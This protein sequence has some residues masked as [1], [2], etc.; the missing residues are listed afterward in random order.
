VNRDRAGNFLK[1]A[2][3]INLGQGRFRFRDAVGFQ[4]DSTD[5]YQ[6]KLGTRSRLNIKVFRQK[7]AGNADVE[8][9]QLRDQKRPMMRHIGRRQFDDLK[10]K[11]IRQHLKRV[12]RSR[13]K[14]RKNE[15]LRLTAEPGIYYIH[16]FPRSG[17][18]QYRLNIK[19]RPQ[20]PSPEPSS[21][22]PASSFSPSRSLPSVPRISPPPIQVTTPN[23][24]EVLTTGTSVPL[25]W[26]DTFD[27]PVQIDLFANNAKVRT[28][29][30]QT[31]SDGQFQWDIPSTLLSGTNYTIRISQSS[32]LAIF[33]DSDA[34]FGIQQSNTADPNPQPTQAFNIQFDYRFDTQ[35]WFTPE[36]KAVLESAAKFWEDIIQDDFD[37]VPAGTRLYVEN[38]E[39][40]GVFEELNIETDID[41]VM[42]FV[43]SRLGDSLGQGGP[44]ALYFP[45][46]VLDDRF[47]GTDFEPWSGFISF[48]RDGNWFFDATP[49]T[50]DDLPSNQTDFLSVAIHEMGHVL[51][52][53]TSKAFDRWVSGTSFLGPASTAE[54]GGNPIPLEA[55]QSHIQ[56]GYEVQNSGELVFDPILKDGDR[57]LPTRLDVAALQDIGY[58]VDY[59]KTFQNA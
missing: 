48:Q 36:R 49:D 14:G 2:K 15:N 5:L 19:A 18:T 26:V 41:D 28:I 31:P 38:P 22:P 11:E 51:G 35:R 16:V 34:P 40:E 10:R 29:V 3:K 46:S 59:R 17:A 12:G 32:N 56:D 24:G 7:Q 4:D 44:S 43:G 13:R 23:G 50:H 39:T 25:S 21:N 20:A 6:V 54:N 33:D 42:I 30:Q 1:K 9:Y 52:Y 55:D 58:V 47:N 45:G 8:L 37:V 53:G 27:G 57:T